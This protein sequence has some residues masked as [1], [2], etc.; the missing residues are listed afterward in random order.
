MA[1]GS[2]FFRMSLVFLFAIRVVWIRGALGEDDRAKDV[3]VRLEFLRVRDQG[4]D[5]F[6]GAWQLAFH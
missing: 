3:V 1:L 5:F 4:A 6:V 2:A